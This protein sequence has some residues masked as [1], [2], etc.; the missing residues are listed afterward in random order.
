MVILSLA[1]A[2]AAQENTFK[3]LPERLHLVG[4]EER[5]DS[6]VGVRQ[7][8]GGEQEGQGH[9]A[10]RAQQQEA[11]DDVQRNPADGEEEEH[12]E[13]RRGRLHLLLDVGGS[14]GVGLAAAIRRDPAHLLLDR[15]EDL[16]VDQEHDDERRQHARKEVEVYHVGH[17]H[18]VD[19]EAEA[20]PGR[21]LV[22]AH[23][24]NQADEES[25]HPR[26][27]DDEQR[28]A[29][30]HGAVVAKGHEDGHVA[31]DSHS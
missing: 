3:G 24:R 7:D 18:H 22:P 26:D 23:E 10:C 19:E 11:V 14:L 1:A 13:E 16:R 12:E 28:V 27:Q 30:R 8:D 31:L 25:Q 20:V 6:R 9:V 29:W 17:L 21:S 2:S 4:V 5:V 15:E